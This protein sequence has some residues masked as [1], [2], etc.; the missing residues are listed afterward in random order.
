MDFS[1]SDWVVKCGFL[2]LITG[3]VRDGTQILDKFFSQRS[4]MSTVREQQKRSD[5]A[6]SGDG[7]QWKLDKCWALGKLLQQLRKCLRARFGM[8]RDSGGWLKGE[9][10]TQ[11]KNPGL[12][13]LL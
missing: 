9:I 6:R 1:P 13:S 2:S 10:K 11:H 12:R 4:R 8:V 3:L 5:S 7:S